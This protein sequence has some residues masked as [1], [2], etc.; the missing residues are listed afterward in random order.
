MC[1]P[2]QLQSVNHT[3]KLLE[4]CTCWELRPVTH[5]TP[6]LQATIY[7]GEGTVSYPPSQRFHCWKTLQYLHIEQWYKHTSVS[8]SLRLTPWN[9]IFDLKICLNKGDLENCISSSGS[10][11]NLTGNYITNTFNPLV[12][13]MYLRLINARLRF[14]PS[15]SSSTCFLTSHLASLIA[16]ITGSGRKSASHFLKCTYFLRLLSE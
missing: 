2:W 16:L 12:C 10:V 6:L 13:L 5:N 15:V 3:P 14:V 9:N 7:S 8:S 4:K 11:K 1:A